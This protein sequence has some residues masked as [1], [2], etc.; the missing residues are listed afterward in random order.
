MVLFSVTKKATTPF[1]GQKPGTSGLRKKVTVFQQPHYLQNFV[2]STFNALPADKVKGATIVVSGDGRYFSKDAVQI[3]TKMAA[4][5]GVRRVWVGQNSLMSTPAVSAVIRERVGADD[6]GIKYNMENGGPAPESVTDKIFSNTTTITEYLIAEDLPDVD[7]SVVGVTTFSG[8]EGPFDVDVFDSTIDYIKLM[9]TIFDFESIKKL[10]ASPKFTF[11]YDALHGVAGTYATRIFVE[12]LGAAES[13]LLNCVPKEDFGGGHPDPNLTYAKELVDRMGLGKSSN[14]EPPEFGAAADGDADRNM[15]LGKRFFVTPSDSVAIIAANAVQSI[16]YFSSGLKGVARSMPTSAALD[17]VAKNLNLKF[18]EVPTGWKFFGNLMDAGMCSI[19]GEESFGT[20]SD[21]IREKDGIWAVLAWLSI[22]AFKNKDN[23]GGDKLVTVEDIVRQHWG[24]Y[25]RHYYTR[26]DYENVD[27]GAAKE[28]MANLVS[29][30]SSLSDV[31]K[32]IKEIRSDVSDVVAADEFEYKDPVDGSVSKH[33]GVRYLFGDG[34]RL[35]FR[36]SGTGS[37]GAT[38]RVYIEQYEKDSS[39]TGRDSQDALAPLRT[40]GVTLEIGRSDRMDEPRVAPV[41]CLALKHGADSDKP[42]LF[43]ISD[44]TAI[45]N[46]GGVDI[47]GLTN[48]N[49]WVTPQGWIRVRSAS[50]A[51]TFL[52]NPQD[53]DGKIPL[54]HL[55]RELPSTC[56]CRLSGKPNGS[57]SCI[58]LLVETEEDVTVL[59]YCRFGGG[60]EGEG[61]VRH[62]YDVGTQWD[63]RPGKEGQREKVP[64]CSIAACRGKFYFNATPESVGVLEFTPTPTAPVFGSIAIADPLPGGY[65]VLGAALGF[66][67]EAED[68]LY[69]VRLLL[70]RDFETVYDLIVYKM[71]FSEQQWHEVDDIGGRAFLLAPAYFGASRAADECGLEK[72]S[73]YVPYAHKKCF[74][75]CKVEEKGDIDV[76]NLIEAPDAKIGMW[77]MPTD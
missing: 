5:N 12:E 3:I 32:L 74:E 22:L 4:A 60:G 38:I 30:Q 57:E 27:A 72:D 61:W 25:G 71:D 8:P 55:P 11:C 59:W 33:Q 1:D 76:V 54:P 6:F 28:L 49:A 65:G 46:N 10:L 44:A 40:G 18:F 66:L 31:N 26:Y 48:G 45:D 39:K 75:V 67:V 15:I 50:D 23:L 47:P 63:I 13:S 41:P 43:S 24:T 2:Q 9:K 68:D 58:V 20:G 51:S 34:S 69:M 53:P 56:S 29:M 77:I 7:I 64:I 19:C 52:Q 62:E 42:V 14:A 70:D 16:P 73:V 36:L 21:H 35:V 17:V 37:V